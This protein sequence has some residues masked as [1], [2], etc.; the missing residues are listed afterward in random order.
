MTDGPAVSNENTTLCKNTAADIE[1]EKLKERIIRGQDALLHEFPWQVSLQ[2]QR[3]HV[4]GGAIVDQYNILTAAHCFMS[5]VPV[6]LKTIKVVLGDLNLNL[7][8]ETTHVTAELHSVLFHSHFDPYYLKNDIA[9]IR[10]RKPIQFRTGIQ[11]VCLPETGGWRT[12]NSENRKEPNMKIVLIILYF[13]GNSYAG[14]HAVISGWGAI[15]F[16][17]GRLATHLQ[18]VENEVIENAECRK[19]LKIEY[20]FSS[21]LC[22]QAPKCAGTCF[23]RQQCSSHSIVV[24]FIVLNR[25]CP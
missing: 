3:G 2:D 24:Y 11:P 21:M 13:L 9:L 6:P 15:N 8:T 22:A 16:P 18:R 25:K 7:T 5:V 19:V 23:V 4:C 1:A 17:M 14:R 20:I 12:V 10:L